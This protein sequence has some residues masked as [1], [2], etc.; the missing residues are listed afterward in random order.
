MAQASKITD[1]FSSRKRILILIA[2][3]A[4]VILATLL[5]L[6]SCGDK[7]T[8]EYQFKKVEKGDVARTIFVTGKIVFASSTTVESEL[9]N[10]FI[11]SVKAG[12]NA[13]VKKGDVLAK[14]KADDTV[15][16]A[17]QTKEALI[18]ANISLEAATD[19]FNLKTN[20]FE[21]KVIAKTE[22]EE[23]KRNLDRA[24]SQQRSSQNAMDKLNKDLE[25]C[26]VKA[27]INGQISQLWAFPNMSISKGTDLF[28]I[29]GDMKKMNLELSIDETDIGS[30]KEGKTVEFSV[31]AY[32]DKKFKGK[33]TSVSTTS[34][35]QGNIVTYK[36]FAECD[37]SSLLLKSGMSATAS[38]FVDMAANV[39]KVP[40]EA[41]TASPVFTDSEPGKRFIW[42][43]IPD[44]GKNKGMKKL[45][46]STG[47]VGNSFTQ[48]TGGNIRENDQIL[49][50]VL[51]KSKGQSIPGL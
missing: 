22:L 40:N 35:M 2:A 43:K 33:I 12:L 26:V 48:I 23:A 41:F 29:V 3:A 46:V 9:S 49:V 30:I 37:N 4:L 27:P 44:D 51:K 45:E 38:V 7:D 17:K 10:G 6:R 15:F 13:K 24:Q 11:E 50:R 19:L 14:I 18:Q 36:A 21:S 39:I 28:Q 34:V 31:S 5:S 42:K 16:N 32:P 1:T 25:A 8:I 47:L 20:F